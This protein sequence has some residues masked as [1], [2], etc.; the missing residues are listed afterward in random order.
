M[1]STAPGNADGAKDIEAAMAKVH[2][3]GHAS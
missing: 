2:R 1:K 3:Q